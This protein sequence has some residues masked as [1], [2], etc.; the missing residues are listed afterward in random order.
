MPGSEKSGVRGR[1][2]GGRRQSCVSTNLVLLVAMKSSRVL[3]GGTYLFVTAAG[4]G[5]K[6]AVLPQV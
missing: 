5:G 6:H 2:R 4:M 3:V 1:G